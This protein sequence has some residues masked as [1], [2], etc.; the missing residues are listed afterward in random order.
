MHIIKN[1]NGDLFSGIK[2]R[3]GLMFPTWGTPAES[4]FNA[5]IFSDEG[6]ARDTLSDLVTEFELQGL[7]VQPLSSRV[8]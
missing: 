4:S 6:A 5:V 7:Q 8:S 1:A 3:V 2:H